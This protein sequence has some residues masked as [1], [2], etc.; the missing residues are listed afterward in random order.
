MIGSKKFGK[1]F[2]EFLVDFWW[3][4]GETDDTILQGLY[5]FGNLQISIDMYIW[6]NLQIFWHDYL[7]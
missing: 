5:V 4:F 1:T 3:I 6:L 7:S 2:G